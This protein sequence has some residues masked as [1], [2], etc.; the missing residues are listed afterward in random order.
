MRPPHALIA[1]LP[2]NDLDASE[3][4]YNRLGFRRLDH[5]GR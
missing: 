1:T 3:A 4:Y 2:C 5:E